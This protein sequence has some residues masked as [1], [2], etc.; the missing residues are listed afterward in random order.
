MSEPPLSVVCF[1]VKEEARFF[2]VQPRTNGGIRTVVTGM[3]ARNAEQ[4]IRKVLEEEKPVLVLTCGFAGGL[5]PELTRGTVVFDVDPET[6][7]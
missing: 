3:G 1:A 4:A 2:Q 7:L 6:K 5:K